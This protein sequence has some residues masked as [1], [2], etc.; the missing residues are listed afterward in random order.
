MMNQF[1]LNVG[2]NGQSIQ[3]NVGL[4]PTESKDGTIIL[5]YIS[6]IYPHIQFV[7]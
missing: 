4:Q 5:T 3:L 6:I 7:N 2:L 1:H